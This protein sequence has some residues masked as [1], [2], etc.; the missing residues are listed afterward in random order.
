MGEAGEEPGTCSRHHGL[1]DAFWGTAFLLGGPQA[2][3]EGVGCMT[4]ASREIRLCLGRDQTSQ[5]R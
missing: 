3:V 5:A 2:L 4:K 1:G